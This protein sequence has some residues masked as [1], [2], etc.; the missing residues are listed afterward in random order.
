MATTPALKFSVTQRGEEQILKLNSE[1]P[2]PV[3]S[4]DGH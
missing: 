1:Y 2:T 3:V 4:V